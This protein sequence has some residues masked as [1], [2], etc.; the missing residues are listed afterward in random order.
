MVRDAT[1]RGR[2]HQGIEAAGVARSVGNAPLETPTCGTVN[3]PGTHG[4]GRVARECRQFIH[5]RPWRGPRRRRGRKPFE[6][7]RVSGDAVETDRAGRYARGAERE[8]G[9]EREN[10]SARTAGEGRVH[11]SILSARVCL[12]IINMSRKVTCFRQKDGGCMSWIYGYTKVT[13]G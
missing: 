4:C 10:S 3:E 9:G 1:G 12:S 2:I 7:L 6:V 8:Q 5:P 11:T 13:M